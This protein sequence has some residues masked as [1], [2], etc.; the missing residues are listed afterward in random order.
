MAIVASTHS[1][2]TG[3]ATAASWGFDSLANASGATLVYDTTVFAN[4]T[5]SVKITQSTGAVFAQWS[6]TTLGSLTDHYGEIY[7]YLTALPSA[8]NHIVSGVTSGSVQGWAID[9]TSTGTVILRN[10]ANTNVKAT[11]STLP[12]NQ[13]V[14]LE[15]HI[16]QASGTGT[17][18]LQVYT[19]ANGTSVTEDTGVITSDYGLNTS[20]VQVGAKLTGTATM[21]AFYVDDV[22]IATGAWIG[23]QGSAVV[24]N[25]TVNVGPDLSRAISQGNVTVTCTATPATGGTIQSYAWTQVSG[26]T[27]TLTNANTATVTVAPP[28]TAGVAQL[29]CTVTQTG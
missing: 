6:S 7:L 25:P 24:A 23:P 3:T 12:L 8:S 4:G 2:G 16:T 28:A 13:W 10:A 20:S 11:T 22:A 29:R 19:A 15:W 5:S 1:E 21:P 14:R 18:Q 27:V 9:V 17:F 26:P